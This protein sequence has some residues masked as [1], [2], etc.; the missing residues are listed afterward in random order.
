[1]NLDLPNEFLFGVAGS[2]HQIEGGN[3]NSDCWVMEHVPSTFF[4]EPSGDACD[5]Y[6]RFRDDLALLAELGLNAYR[7]SL[8]WSRI[9]P[10]PGLI[11]NA[12][13]DHYRRVLEQC[14]ECNLTPIVTFN[15][16]T[17]PKW[18][19]ARRGFEVKG[20][21]G[22]FADYCDVAAK[23]LGDLLEFAA[24]FNEPNIGLTL[25]LAGIIPPDDVMV[26]MPARREAALAVGSNDFAGFPFCQQAEAPYNIIAAHKLASRAIKARNSAIKT[27]LTLAT[28]DVV[29]GEGEGAAEQCE[30]VNQILVGQFLPAL[31]DDD[32]I[33]AQIY[34]RIR[35]GGDGKPQFDPLSELTQAGQEFYPEATE[36][37]LLYLKRHSEVPV[38]ITEN[39]VAHSD[40]S[41]RVLYI[42][43]ALKGMCNAMDQ[44]VKVLGYCHWSVFDN[45]EW[46]FGYGPHYGIIAVDRNT[47]KRTPK[48]SA[49]LLGQIARA[50]SLTKV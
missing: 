6:H 8:E 3:T 15:H 27:G 10:E 7:F 31:A 47:F 1:M 13:L 43:R 33:G 40:D 35:I 30:R 48:P 45:Y 5:H 22:L 11:S 4:A 20:N 44:G 28:Q 12:A 34:T 37:A 18:F 14:H 23:H 32:F 38:L 50:A 42:E 46:N 21:E 25:Q 24:T 9:E 41:M 49:R 26:D 29:P 16:F 36:G 2:G 39:G 17:T 19:A